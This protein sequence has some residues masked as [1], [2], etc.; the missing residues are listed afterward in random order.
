MKRL[1]LLVVV[2]IVLGGTTFAKNN[3]ES[4]EYAVLSKLNSQ[5]KVDG[6]VRY[7]NANTSQKEYLEEIFALSTKKMEREISKQQT[8]ETAIEKIVAFNLANVKSVLSPEQYRKYLTILNMT[9][10]NTPEA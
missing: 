8:P 3:L 4:K 9:M 7:L 2:S 6:L 5:N 1:L 10:N